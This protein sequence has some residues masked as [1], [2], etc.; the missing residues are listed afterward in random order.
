MVRRSLG[1][2]LWSVVGLF[3]CFLGG[4]SA[5][6]GTGAGRGLLARIASRVVAGA[7]DGR[8]TVGNVSGSLLT[9]TI[10]FPCRKLAATSSSIVVC[11]RARDHL[12]VSGTGQ[13]STFLPPACAVRA[14]W[15]IDRPRGDALFTTE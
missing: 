7:I 14:E 8:I 13:P 1:A 15:R 2:A 4:L 5:L 3:A 6:V 12:Y 11:T 9:G 10:G